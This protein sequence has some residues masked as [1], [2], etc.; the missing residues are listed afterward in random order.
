MSAGTLLMGRGLHTFLLLPHTFLA[1]CP[2]YT[3]TLFLVPEVALGQAGSVLSK[4]SCS[5][6]KPKTADGKRGRKVKSCR[7]VHKSLWVVTQ[8]TVLLAQPHHYLMKLIYALKCRCWWKLQ[9]KLRG[10]NVFSEFRSYIHFIFKFM[11][12]IEGN[13]RHFSKIDLQM[14]EG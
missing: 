12:K 1:P 8:G 7:H 2:G 10:L 5:C 13:G 6:A 9:S 3:R 11:V 14:K 4:P